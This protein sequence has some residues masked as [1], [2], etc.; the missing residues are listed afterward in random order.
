MNQQQSNT[1]ELTK[2]LAE[3]KEQLAQLATGGEQTHHVAGYAYG[4]TK[5]HRDAFIVLYPANPRLERKIVRVYQEQFEL[6]PFSI[7]PNDIPDAPGDNPTRT[8]AQNQGRYRDTPPFHI[9]TQSGKL[10]PVGHERRFVSARLPE[11]TTIPAFTPNSPDAVWVIGKTTKKPGVLINQNGDM[12]QVKIGDKIYRI[13]TK[14]LKPR[15]I[16]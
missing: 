9:T 11:N 7:N 4:R 10:T 3:I 16:A 8:Q 12:A 1:D 5:T 6:L 2:Q 14:R 13:K 15:N